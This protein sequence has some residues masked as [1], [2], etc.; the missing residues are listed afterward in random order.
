MALFLNILSMKA[1]FIAWRLLGATWRMGGD[2][3]LGAGLRE[4]AIR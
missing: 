4:I 1:L 3:A 2:W